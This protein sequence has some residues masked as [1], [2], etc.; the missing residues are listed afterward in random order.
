MV[1]TPRRETVMP[2]SE[3]RRTLLI[4]IIAATAMFAFLMVYD[5][6]MSATYAPALMPYPVDAP[7]L[8]RRIGRRDNFA[9]RMADPRAA[10][11]YFD[12]IITATDAPE[13]AALPNLAA[14]AVM[15]EITPLSTAADI[16][17]PDAFRAADMRI[18]DDDRIEFASLIRPEEYDYG[19]Y[20]SLAVEGTEREDVRGFLHIPL[21]W[22][23]SL[24]PAPEGWGAAE[25]VGSAVSRFTGI[26]TVEDQH[27][28]L[29]S[30]RLL[31][32]PVLYLTARYLFDI[33]PRE[34][35]NLRRYLE[36][37]GFIIMDNTAPK[38]PY[39]G[40]EAS[41]KKMMRNVLGSRGRLAPIPK[42]HPLYHSVFDFDRAP[43]GREIGSFTVAGEI[44][45]TGTPP[46]IT[47]QS[48]E[49]YYLE[50]FWFDDRLAGIFT[51]KGYTVDL[52]NELSGTD[53]HALL[54]PW[55]GGII[56]TSY[57]DYSFSYYSPSYGFPWYF[58]G[59]TEYRFAT[60][61]FVT[62][63]VGYALLQPDG[64]TQRQ[65]RAA[66]AD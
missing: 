29:D 53:V 34:R 46:E 18:P 32:Y 44:Y 10:G 55:G 19:R 31:D 17:A 66:L 51:D 45:M 40:L 59:S 7:Q 15:W 36:A 60:F 56:F 14:D 8:V 9:L 25:R 33:S 58:G 1:D 47:V 48:K 35:E 37:G 63:M 21:V 4:A 26:Q 65:V 22:G 41:F 6:P 62:N 24:E 54:G 39:N 50:G 43:I 28:Y 27:V 52:L 64:M 5:E 20:K 30:P 13:P 49:Q 2:S 16:D 23:T 11:L 57:Y 3:I 12:R 42:D 61:K 38:L